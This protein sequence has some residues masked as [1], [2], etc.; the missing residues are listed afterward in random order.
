MQWLSFY[1]KY[2]PSLSDNMRKQNV[3]CPFHEDKE[4]SMSIDVETGLWYCHSDQFGGDVFSFYMRYHNA[5]FTVA[6]SVITGNENTP[7]LTQTEVDVAHVQLLQSEDLQKML[8]I[9][10][11]WTLDT[12]KKYQIGWMRERVYIP[13]FDKDSNLRNI[14]KYDIL[15]K[16]NTKFKGI[17]GYNTIRL[18][19]EESLEYETVLIFAGEPDTLLALQ[20]GFPAI[21]FTGGEGNFREALLSSFADKSVYVVY[22]IDN[23]G[24][25]ASKILASKLTEHAKDVHIIQLPEK[26][27]PQKGDF[28]DL[29]FLCIDKDGDFMETW[30]QLVAEAILVEKEIKKDPEYE[31]T[32]FFSS[33][34]EF[35][36]DK[37][38][39]FKAIAIGKNFSPYFSPKLL[40][41]TCA[42]TK[43]EHCKTCK[44]FFTGGTTNIEVTDKNTLDLIKCSQTE[45]KIKIKNIAGIAACTMF[46]CEVVTQ[47][48][49]E[50]FIAPVIDSEVIDRQF[51]VRKCYTLSHNI[52][53]NKTYKFKGKT[54]SDAKTQEATHFF[55]EQIPEQ[56]DL[57]KF[58]LSEDDVERLRTFNANDGFADMKIKQIH[59]DLTYN[60]PEIIV[61]R[62]NLMLAYDLVFHSVLKF[63]IFDTVVEKGWLEALAI[64][65]TRTGKTKIALKLCKHYRLGEYITLE[66]ATLPG[67]IGGMAQHGRDIAFSW[68][69]LPINDGRL[70]IMDEANGLDARDIS[71]LSSIRDNGIAE[72]T[73]VGSTRKT[74]ARVRMVWIS[75]PRGYSTKISQYSSGVEAIRELMGRPE[76]ISRLDFAIVIA[77]EDVSLQAM[78]TQSHLKVDHIYTSELCNKLIMWAW[79][80]KPRD[81]YFEDGAEKAI[82]HHAMLMA[83]KYSDHIPLVQGSVQRIKIAKMAAACA[84]RLFSTNDGIKLI[85]KIEHV[86]FVVNYLCKI[87]D[88]VYF[89]YEEYSKHRKEESEVTAIGIIESYIESHSRSSEQFVSKLLNANTILFEDLI[90]F[91]GMSRDDA[92]ELKHLLVTNNCIKRKKTFYVKTPEFVTLLKKM[93]DGRL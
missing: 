79:S 66:S 56:T 72:R 65:D 82:L 3:I 18:W 8:L 68:G 54:I 55:T 9:K 15:H 29:F 83:N 85:V 81:I 64:G 87:Y 91:S 4:P 69:I 49:E 43:G 48:L 38:I 77:K 45:Q 76:D 84:A 47:A 31:E 16:T 44:L 36:Y 39:T 53:L 30:N 89:G 58:Q 80:R 46:N 32:D 74:T 37:H 90:D 17:Q 5:S 63:K 11:G 35:Y 62:E 60:I 27:L 75:N 10:R 42:F 33:V 51:I 26:G 7:I 93:Q 19:P 1:K 23:K 67:L 61:G 24:K 92:K 12:I 71:N 34:Q 2:F 21:T 73:I 22:D 88:S 14:R 28:T 13:I 57:D 40:K 70:V 86:E 41:L 20:L 50:I 52:Q 25:S 78:N 6:K 59:R